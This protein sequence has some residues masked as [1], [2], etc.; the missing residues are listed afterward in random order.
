MENK[1]SN[2]KFIAENRKAYHDYLVLERLEAG[3]SL[4]GT[5]IKSIRAHNVNLRDSYALIA[6]EEIWLNDM[7]V[8]PYKE[9]SYFNHEPKR[10]RRLL[11]NK[12]EIR[13]WIGK[14]A[15]KGLTI[16][17]LK[18]YFKGNWVKVELA[19]VK[20]KKLYDKREDLMKKEHKR[21]IERAQ[22]NYQ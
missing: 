9:A 11:V 20:G 19:L 21:I 6:K 1:K 8:S 22:K 16:V 5:E 13:K 18:L 4:T 2:P 7:H 10:S 15:E 17:P 12:R 14:V 3:I